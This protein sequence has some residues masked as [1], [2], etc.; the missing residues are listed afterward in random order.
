MAESDLRSHAKSLTALVEASDTF[1]AKQ[2]AQLRMVLREEFG[3][4]G[5]RID[6]PDHIDEARRDFVFLRSFRRG[7]SGLASKIGWAVILAIL[8]AVMWLVNSGLTFW[9]TH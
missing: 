1:S 2:L 3:D 4:V 5:L 8:G 9:K 7:A 6:G